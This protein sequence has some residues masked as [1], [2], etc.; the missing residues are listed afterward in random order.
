MAKVSVLILARNEEKFIGAC[1]D[2]VK[3]F[4][5]EI[6]VIDDCSTDKTAEIC[7]SHGAKVFQRA[8]NGDW[9][10]QQTFAVNQATCDW[11]FII[12]ADERVTPELATE[13]KNILR[14]DD[15]NFAYR[16]ARLSYFWGLVS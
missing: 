13:I 16:V 10:A 1:L 15:K 3:N 7:K 14:G 6:I 9:G 11:I 8:L 5:D 2:S 4:A 12:D